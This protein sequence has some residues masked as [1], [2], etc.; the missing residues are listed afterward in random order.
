[1]LLGIE[2]LNLTIMKKFTGFIFAVLITLLFLPAHSLKAQ[3]KSGV[4]DS[5]YWQIQLNSGTSLF[6]GDVKQNKFWPVSSNQNEWRL[7]TGLNVFRQFS[8]VLSAGGQALYG[9]LSGTRRDANQYFESDYFE[10]TLNANLSLTNLIWK[11]NPSRHYNVYLLA[12]IGLTNYNSTVYNLAT[13]AV[14]A[15][16]G[17]GN[18]S[19][20]GGRTLEGIL[21]G[22]IGLSYQLNNKL[23]LH[24]ET[25]NHIM[26]S[27]MM[28]H[29]VRSF[30]YDVYNYT[31]FGISY[32]LGQKR[33]VMP[34]RVI[35]ATTPK[36]VTG[37]RKPEPVKKE[38]TLTPTQQPAKKVTQPVQPPVKPVEKPV[39]KPKDTNTY[40][41]TNQVKPE[42]VKTY[43]KQ[44]YKSPARPVLEYRVQIRARYGKA[45][46]ISYLKNK[47]HI[48]HATIREDMHDGYY[49]YTIGSF[50]TYEQARAA[51]DTLRQVNGIRD[52]FVVAFK[53]GYRLDKL[54]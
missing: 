26:N 16:V 24:F 11:N 53:N 43:V 10:F 25:T 41:A 15:Q 32:K 8:P 44:Q 47:Y 36:T 1:M 34:G 6:F 37:E 27:D 31:S 42:A 18:G 40:T 17:H 22:G 48:T 46:S 13:G 29:W 51:R 50:D 52:A 5:P 49:I 12:G 4:S 30:K 14:I 2:R 19:S 7:G 39:E 35:K 38:T 28:D 9:Q 54:P 23:S 20:F 33:K 45:L 3:S 21:T